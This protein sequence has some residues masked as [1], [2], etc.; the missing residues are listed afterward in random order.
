MSS[1]ITRHNACKA[2]PPS[3]EFALKDIA[4]AHALSQTGHAI[5]K[6]ALYVGQP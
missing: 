1:S 5:G 2:P 4:A 6:I 3:A